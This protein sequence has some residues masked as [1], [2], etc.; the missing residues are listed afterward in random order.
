MVITVLCR[1]KIK[2]EMTCIEKQWNSSTVKWKNAAPSNVYLLNLEMCQ[3]CNW[4]IYL[5]SI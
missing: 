1:A 4:N 5:H 3:K 2:L